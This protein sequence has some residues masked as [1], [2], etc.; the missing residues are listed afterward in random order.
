MLLRYWGIRT[1]LNTLVDSCVVGRHGESAADL[2]RVAQLFGCDLRAYACELDQLGSFDAPVILHWGFNHWVVLDTYKK[3]IA[4]ILDPAVGRRALDSSILSR[5]FTGV[6]LKVVRIDRA[7]E[8]PRDVTNTQWRLVL[9]GHGKLLAHLFAVAIALTLVAQG[10]NVA[11]A[12]GFRVL[13]NTV[14]PSSSDRLMAYFGIVMLA[15]IAGKAICAYIRASLLTYFRASL[16]SSLLPSILEHLLHLPI[17]F[18]SARFTTDLSSRVDNYNSLRQLLSDTT[19]TALIDGLMILVYIAVIGFIA[20]SAVPYILLTACVYLV[21]VYFRSLHER[22][23]IAL[24]LE[25]DIEQRQALVEILHGIKYIKGTG[26][27]SIALEK[28][29]RKYRRQLQVSSDKNYASSKWDGLSD[30]C[31]ALGPLLAILAIASRQHSASDVGSLITVLILT[32]SI[33]GPLSALVRTAHNFQY[34]RIYAARLAG[35]LCKEREPAGDGPLSL[36]S[37]IDVSDLSYVY[38]GEQR[39]AIQDISCRFSPNTTTVI[40]GANGSGKSTLLSVLVGLRTALDGQIRCNGVAVDATNIGTLRRA[41]GIVFQEESLYAG[42]IRSNICLGKPDA[43]LFEV[44]EAARLAE[45]HGEVLKLP[46]GYETYIS[47]GGGNISGGQRQ[48]IAMARALIAKPHLLILDEATS[49]M[50]LESEQRVLTTLHALP[51]I[52]IIVSH[53]PSAAYLADQILEL[54]DGNLV[55]VA[56]LNRNLR[57]DEPASAW[58]I[59]RVSEAP[60]SNHATFS[61]SAIGVPAF[62]GA[63]DP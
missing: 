24:E 11:V 20:P 40:T 55:R 39:P 25:A 23:I 6:V 38:P 26:M 61:R 8:A 36:E 59:V 34:G 52:K 2:V 30:T 45:L 33:F 37:G 44:I 60:D 32:N 29:T 3:G 58:S 53:R 62:G 17:S 14:L 12:Y 1:S 46:G 31:S 16:D 56:S 4:H 13:L 42:S 27:E 10:L 41:T 19:V 7:V 15:L 28:W 54:Q 43:S 9:K 47:E 57:T 48:R 22:D 21:L 51:C 50:D 63:R 5:K 18:F 35:I 49:Q